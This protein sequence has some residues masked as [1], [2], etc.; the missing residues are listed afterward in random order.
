MGRRQTQEFLT[1]DFPR[2]FNQRIL[3]FMAKKKKSKSKRD[4]SKAQK[5]PQKAPQEENSI[6]FVDSG[7]EGNE[8]KFVFESV[9][10]KVVAYTYKKDW[11]QMLAFPKRDEKGSPVD[12]CEKENLAIIKSKVREAVKDDSL[13]LKSA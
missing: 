9:Y 10:Y 4:V 11:L 6:V 13:L 5:A 3:N 7:K 1:F 2:M 12:G 8:D